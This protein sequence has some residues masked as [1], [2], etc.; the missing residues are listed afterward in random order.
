MSDTF[1]LKDLV[2]GPKVISELES[3][4]RGKGVSRGA[5]DCLTMWFG[6]W[7]SL[8][9]KPEGAEG[10]IC[11]KLMGLE[12]VDIKLEDYPDL[13]FL[14]EEEEYLATQEVSEWLRL[15]NELRRRFQLRILALD[16]RGRH[17]FVVHQGVLEEFIKRRPLAPLGIPNLALELTEVLTLKTD[18]KH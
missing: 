9:T 2:N 17:F 16:Q 8:L 15:F 1:D 13:F 7:F 18:V 11:Y 3:F 6:W 10:G 4:L 14:N 12:E 5:T